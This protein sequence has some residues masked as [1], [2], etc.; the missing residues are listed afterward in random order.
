[1]KSGGRGRSKKATQNNQDLDTAAPQQPTKS[2]AT[3]KGN[4]YQSA[5]ANGHIQNPETPQGGAQLLSDLN[6]PIGVKKGQGDNNPGPAGANR[7]KKPFYK[8]NFNNNTGGNQNYGNI[9][10]NN[11]QGAGKNWNQNYRKQFDSTCN[12]AED[13][14]YNYKTGEKE[15]KK[16]FYKN[17][18]GN[19]NWKNNGNGQNWNNNKSNWNKSSNDTQNPNGN[20]NNQLT[21]DSGNGQNW[22]QNKRQYFAQKYYQQ[23]SQK[24]PQYESAT[25][26]KESQ[27]DDEFKYKNH[28]ENQKIK[29]K[30]VDEDES[31]DKYGFG[32]SMPYQTIDFNKKQVKNIKQPDQKQVGGYQQKQLFAKAPLKGSD[33]KGYQK[34]HQQNQD[35]E[36][37]QDMHY[38]YGGEDF[39][40]SK[41]SKNQNDNEEFGE[42]YY[43]ED[44]EYGE[45]EEE[46]EEEAGDGS[47]KQSYGN[48]S[49]NNKCYNK[50][51][52][53]HKAI[54]YKNYA[55][56]QKIIEQMRQDGKSADEIKMIE[57]EED[58]DGRQTFN[59]LHAY[60]F[61]IAKAGMENF[62]ENKVDQMLKESIT[63]KQYYITQ[64]EKIEKVEAKVAAY[65]A[66]IQQYRQN[67]Q[68]WEK[69]QQEVKRRLE[70]YRK[71]RNI[72]RTWLHVDMDMFYAAIE[73]R[74][75][76]DLKEKPVAV[77]DYS[78][79]QTTN[80]VARE[81]GVRSAMP[82]FMGKKLCPTLV[83]IR[84]NKDKYRKVSD[85]EFKAI[86][87][88]YD[89]KLE[90]IGL[91]E[92][93][94]DIT[95]FLQKNGMD[96]P[97]GR[98]FVAEKIREQIK[99][100][101]QMTS[102]VGIASNKMLAKICSEL[103][104]PNGQSYLAFDADKIEEFM[105]AKKVR[106]VP[107]VG[108][109]HEQVLIGLDINTCDEIL[110]KAAD[111]YI[112]FTETAFEF[113]V[114]AAM[115]ISRCSHDDDSGNLA[116]RSISFSKSF[117]VISRFEQFKEKMDKLATNLAE[118]CNEMKILARTLSIEFKTEK[119]MLKQRSLT[120]NQHICHK[121]DIM[122]YANELLN[123]V[124]PVE[125]C[126]MMMLKLN[127]LRNRTEKDSTESLLKDVKNLQFFMGKGRKK[128]CLTAAESTGV[129]TLESGQKTLQFNQAILNQPPVQPTVSAV[130]YHERK[131]EK[132]DRY[133][134]LIGQQ[135][136]KNFFGKPKKQTSEANTE[137]QQNQNNNVKNDS[138]N[139]SQNNEQILQQKFNSYHD[140]E[141]DEISRKF[142]QI[143]N[144]DDDYLKDI[145][146]AQQ[147][148]NINKSKQKQQLTNQNIQDFQDQMNKISFLQRR[149]NHQSENVEEEDIDEDDEE[150]GE[151]LQDNHHEY[152]YDDF[153]QQQQQNTTL[154]GTKSLTMGIGAPSNL[155]NLQFY[156]E[157]EEIEEDEEDIE[158]ANQNEGIIEGDVKA[159][160]QEENN[161][162][163]DNK[164][165]QK[166]NDKKQP[167]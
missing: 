49:N 106:D 111:I 102:S 77:G 48:Y 68:L 59:H 139:T 84:P 41:P 135:D 112:N 45:E 159:S 151:E 128:G 95:D 104:K 121:D 9:S 65:K 107:G 116:K 137:Q 18:Y 23:K 32:G 132:E 38:E 2:K 58:D 163:S 14:S 110:K 19:Q 162:S 96:C 36:E 129:V 145:I 146:M 91:D 33:S 71:E 17:N 92:A 143:Q 24:Q 20:T 134:K 142:N 126:R 109:V 118:K 113:L 50:F 90:S 156:D 44:F 25:I 130:I 115:G 140:S 97:E 98:I 99:T 103:N 85:T 46:A 63:N 27:F 120:F 8:K 125:P 101:M 144:D 154:E 166:T 78:M 57:N 164:D 4:R 61:G 150:E 7:G 93:N 15:G 53:N 29:L 28:P 3:K 158:Q 153:D 56:K 75:R 165:E 5:N 86:L 37:D 51:Q 70:I 42:E 55:Q 43:Q 117:K 79:I 11:N 26:T 122:R 16:Y 127:N 82:G 88:E 114:K 108:R 161:S 167:M 62:N 6:K 13:D 69:T 147:Q 12:G 66:K 34:S 81:F 64:E 89:D 54:N 30:Q 22:V 87:R 31:V 131:K 155:D 40:Q 136:I 157:E 80:Y 39:Y 60:N 72:T 76:P 47:N 148:Q 94:L 133:K 74:D 52:V 152:D 21:N 10:Y 119:F 149:Q 100:K 124:W 73:I 83:F 105:R 160:G 67:T 123:A 1:M 138:G 35:L 141:D